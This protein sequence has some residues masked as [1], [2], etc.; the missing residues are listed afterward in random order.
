[1][2]SSSLWPHRLQPARLL[3]PWDSPDK[4]AGVG[5]HALLPGIFQ[6]QG[7]NPGLLHCRQTLYRLSYW[8]SHISK[9]GA[10][11]TLC[12]LGALNW[13]ERMVKWLQGITE[14]D[15]HLSRN[16]EKLNWQQI[17]A[18]WNKVVPLVRLTVKYEA[19]KLSGTAGGS[20]TLFN[21][22]GG[23]LATLNVIKEA[24]ILPPSNFTSKIHTLK[25][26]S[27]VCSRRYVIFYSSKKSCTKCRRDEWYVCVYMCVIKY[28]SSLNT[29]KRLC[30]L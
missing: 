9:L 29:N 28:I 23:R 6:T 2:T 21:H 16:P 27:Q 3:C 22:F 17:N 5:C 18:N 14:E 26:W 20:I 19:N 4:N 10:K 30:V 7:S 11:K 25:K 24:H 15:T 13:P 12:C 8:Q 1:M